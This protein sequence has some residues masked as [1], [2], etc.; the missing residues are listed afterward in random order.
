MCDCPVANVSFKMPFGVSS[1]LGKSGHSKTAQAGFLWTVFFMEE[2]VD[3]D[4]LFRHGVSIRSSLFSS[5]NICCGTS[6]KAEGDL[7]LSFFGDL[8][9]AGYPSLSSVRA[10]TLLGCACSRLLGLLEHEAASDSTPQLPSINEM[11]CESD[12]MSCWDILAVL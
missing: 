8:S 4:G 3:L 12:V 9:I 10:D 1:L 5:S 11:S 7:R 6:T 2:T